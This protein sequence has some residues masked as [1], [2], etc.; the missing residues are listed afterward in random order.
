[1]GK[2]RWQA[3]KVI[4]VK[5]F[6]LRCYARVS[7]SEIV[8]RVERDGDTA[9]YKEWGMSKLMGLGPA[10]Y[11]AAIQTDESDIRP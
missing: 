6:R 9:K 10:M 2:V 4:T 11:Q 3:E 1:M 8:V 7:T 5:K